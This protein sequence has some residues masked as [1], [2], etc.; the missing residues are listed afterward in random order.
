MKDL[1]VVLASKSY[2]IIRYK[3]R[4]CGEKQQQ[5]EG[6]SYAPRAAVERPTKWSE[7]N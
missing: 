4:R 5:E 3:G 6:R 1:V 2:S 7:K